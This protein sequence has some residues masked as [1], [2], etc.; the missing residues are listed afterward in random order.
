VPR[1]NA[2]L[3]I[4]NLPWQITEDHLAELFQAFGP[5]MEVR[6]IQDPATGQ[7]RGYGFVELADAECASRAVAMLQG[8]ELCGRALV[9]SFAHPK[10]P[11]Q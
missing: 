9:I 4:S 2:T 3:Y 11:R 10:P 5:V 6:I 7:S 1:Q 8:H